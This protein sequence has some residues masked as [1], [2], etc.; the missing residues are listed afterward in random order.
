MAITAAAL[1][2]EYRTEALRRLADEEFDVLVIGAGV[3]GA[4]AALDAA[5]RGLKVALVE[6]RDFASGTSSRSSK[7]VHGG[8]RYLKQLNFSLVFEALRE[9]K[10]IL[11]TLCPHLARPVEFIYPLEKSFVDRAWVGT[12]VGVYDV[13][14][15]G[16]GVPHHLRHL[17]KKAT[18]RSFRSGK[19]GAIKGGI[20]F[21]EGQLDDARHTMMIARTA[22]DYGAAVVSSCR[23]TSFLRDGATVTG[24]V[25]T[26][27]ESGTEVRIRAKATINAAGVWTDDI[28][29]MIG[30]KGQ[31]RVTASKGVHVLVP[32]DRI[33]SDTGLITETE[34]SLLF[35]IP[36]PW[37]DEFWIIGT[38]DTTWT[39]DRA[40]PAASQADIDYI[41]A[42]A[43]KL[44]AKPLTRDDV[45]GVYA[46]LRPLLAGESDET[47][48]L[49]REHACV[50]PV[51]GLVIIAGGKYT[52]YR[53]MAKDAVDLGVKVLDRPVPPCLTDRVPLVGA[54]GYQALLNTREALAAR[55]GLTVDRIDHLLGRYGS[56]VREV[57][58]LVAEHPELGEPLEHAPRYLKVEAY[59]G[60]SHEGALHLDDLLA[61]RLRV[62]VDTWDRGVDVAHEVADIVA[63]LLGWDGATIENEVEHYRKR[64][65]AERESQQQ[66]DDRTADSARLGA[67]EVRTGVS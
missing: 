7:L 19:P 16:R 18:L 36:C 6:A 2:P 3:V 61:R 67:P 5:S 55:S 22:A 24:A 26:D 29:E 45:V 65:E 57:L 44:L 52:T 49:S 12:G 4:G 64:V 20:A 56:A 9:R 11:E 53:V 21:Y 17:S 34:K 38:T 66:V 59:Y 35:I 47:S 32:R 46:G 15:A 13:L 48:K 27:L 50:S 23:V 37:S 28:Q 62:S 14:G 30:G 63:P 42:Q 39:L 43:N 25:A 8:L 60:A 41:L 40:H 54:A 51:P 31:F 10:L 1:G 33:D 58:D